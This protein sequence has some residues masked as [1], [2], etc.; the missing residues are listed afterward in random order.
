MRD[1]RPHGGAIIM[2]YVFIYEF[3]DISFLISHANSS[4]ARAAESQFEDLVARDK[5][6]FGEER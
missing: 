4:Q 5:L 1:T 3:R 2:Q 6:S